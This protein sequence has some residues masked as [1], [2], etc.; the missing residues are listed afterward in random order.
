MLN[1][2][3]TKDMVPCYYWSFKVEEPDNFYRSFGIGDAIASGCANVGT[4]RTVFRRLNEE[5]GAPCV[6]VLGD[7]QVCY[8]NDEHHY[9]VHPQQV[10]SHLAFVQE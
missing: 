8:L 5:T 7:D 3:I 9:T 4:L 10:A 6:L 2:R 1:E